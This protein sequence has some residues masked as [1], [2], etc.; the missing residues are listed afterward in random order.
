[1]T[2]EQPAE[3]LALWYLL[4]NNLS[5]LIEKF[6][7]QGKHMEA[8]FFWHRLFQYQLWIFVNSL[9]GTFLHCTK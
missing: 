7:E 1:M 5:G 9:H 4:D 6:K 2:S 3:D 8:D